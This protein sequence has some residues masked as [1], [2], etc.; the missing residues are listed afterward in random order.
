MYLTYD[1]YRAM[2]GTLEKTTFVDLERQA[3]QIVDDK[4]FKR[5]KGEK[6]FPIEVKECIYILIGLQ[7]QSTMQLQGAVA[8]SDAE[9]TIKS[10]SNDGVSVSY[11]IID[12]NASYDKIQKSMD[13]TVYACLFGV[14]NSKGQRLL[15][16]G[17]YPNE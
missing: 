17:L 10:Q 7:Y 5:L 4:T 16:R 1:E 15:Y 13:D 3:R 12:A 8:G 6:E 11:N 2:G 14:E 9:P